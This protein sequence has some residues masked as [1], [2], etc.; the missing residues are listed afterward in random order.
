MPRAKALPPLI[1][2]IGGH[3]VAIRQETGEEL[4]RTKIKGSAYITVTQVG[5]R[6]F[7]GAG[8]ELFCIDA[9][10]GAL[11]WHNK[12]KGLGHGLIGFAGTDNMSSS[13]AAIAAQQAAAVAVIAATA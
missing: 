4:W 10:S 8:G 13:A 9:A 12:L 7:A 5:V 1:I 6:V 11:L 2:G 3:V